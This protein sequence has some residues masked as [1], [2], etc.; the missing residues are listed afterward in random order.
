MAKKYLC[1]IMEK[2]VDLTNLWLYQRHVYLDILAQIL[3]SS[4]R[5]FLSVYM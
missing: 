1:Y 2:N 5:I 3:N 4:K